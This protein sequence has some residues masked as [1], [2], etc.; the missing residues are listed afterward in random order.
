MGALSPVI[1]PADFDKIETDQLA[2]QVHRFGLNHSVLE[3]DIPMLLNLVGR[4]I[5]FSLKITTRSSYWIEA[6]PSSWTTFSLGRQTSSPL[7][8]RNFRLW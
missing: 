8:A 5:P 6:A 4:S 2:K 1:M 3:F 7:S